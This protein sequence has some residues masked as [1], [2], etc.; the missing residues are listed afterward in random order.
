VPQP[1]VDFAVG[2]FGLFGQ[3][4]KKP[5]LERLLAVD[6]NRRAD[7]TAGFAVNMVTPG[8]T[9]KL[10]A[11]PLQQAGENPSP[12]T[13]SKSDFQNAFAAVGFR[14]RDIYAQAA[15]NGIV[16]IRHELVHGFA[17]RGA[18]GDRRHFGPKAAFLC[19]VNDDLDL[20]DCRLTYLQ[21]L[22]NAAHVAAS[23]D[24]RSRGNDIHELS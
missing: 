10:P 9:E 13:A 12:T 6:G 11:V 8:Y 24:S 20:H 3:V 23:M 21:L 5:L 19:V 4:A 16:Q 2:D 22:R 15:F 7:D 18:T 17:L 1:S 14:L